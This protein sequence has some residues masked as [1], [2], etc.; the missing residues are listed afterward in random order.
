MQPQMSWVSEW[1]QR[2]TKLL[3]LGWGLSACGEA[4]RGA[5]SRVSTVLVAEGS[6]GFG[7]VFAAGGKPGT[8]TV[9]ASDSKA[10]NGRHCDLALDDASAVADCEEYCTGAS[11]P[12]SVARAASLLDPNDESSHCFTLGIDR[13]SVRLDCEGEEK[14]LPL[15]D[16]I[17]SDADTSDWA[18]A[19]DIGVSPLLAVAAPDARRVWF[20]AGTLEGP[21]EIDVMGQQS[22]AGF[23]A[24]V[25]LIRFGTDR[26]HSRLIAVGAP[27]AG[28]VWLTRSGFPSIDAPFRVGCLGERPDFGRRLGSGDV[29][30][31]G[32]TDLLVVDS[33]FVTAFSGAALA[34]VSA[35]QATPACSLASLPDSAILAS[36]SCASGGLTSGCKD[37]DFGASLAVA[38][39]DGDADGEII[40]GAPGMMVSGKQSGA[41]L[42]YD[43]EAD[44]PHAFAEAVVE[45]SL[46]DGARFGASL[47]VVQA[48]NVD[49]VMVGAPGRGA[50]FLAPCFSITR[51]ELRPQICGGS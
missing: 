26:F 34:T 46:S 43:A 42:V 40:V 18:F 8:A 24:D 23:G 31:D 19:A 4:E 51:P 35:D 6:E 39:L 33:E 38:D 2:F 27:D 11:C 45:T 20:Y 50:I 3:L 41:V 17:A 13:G 47:G 1:G 10:R 16:S 48:K 36:V 37:A 21:V 29:D 9:W 22:P 30:G 25:A 32:L 14:L 15:P 49:A 28:Q 7:A 5:T 44:D 12:T